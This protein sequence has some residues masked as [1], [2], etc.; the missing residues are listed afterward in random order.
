[1]AGD[2]MKD[3][4]DL[5]ALMGHHEAE[6]RGV[7]YDAAMARLE[8]RTNPASVFERHARQAL[9]AAKQ[10]HTATAV[11]HLMGVSPSQWHNWQSG[12]KSPSH[13]TMRQ[14]LVRWEE[15]GYPPVSL[16]IT[17]EGAEAFSREN[18]G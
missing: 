9:R 10:P 5:G 17:S 16:V 15:A 2:S 8:A 6:A 3:G 13:K 4:M 11:A 12:R 18:P 7:D 1:M 14:W